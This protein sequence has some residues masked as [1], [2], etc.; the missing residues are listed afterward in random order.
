MRYGS[1]LLLL[2]LADLAVAVDRPQIRNL[3]T[4]L[5]TNGRLAG[6]F[7]QLVEDKYGFGLLFPGY[8]VGVEKAVRHKIGV[9]SSAKIDEKIRLNSVSILERMHLTNWLND[10]KRTFI[11]H[12]VK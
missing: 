12:I 2:V 5:G 10:P 6:E 1:I 4:E 3:E 7:H 8:I 11:S 9:V